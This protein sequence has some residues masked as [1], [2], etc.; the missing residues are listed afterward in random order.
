MF[1]RKLV[2]IVFN[3]YFFCFC[4]WTDF[5]NCW[6]LLLT[7]WLTPAQHK[8]I[9]AWNNRRERD[10]YAHTNTETAAAAARRRWKRSWIWWLGVRGPYVIEMRDFYSSISYKTVKILIFV[11]RITCFV[12]VMM[13]TKNNLCIWISLFTQI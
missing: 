9:Y 3:F 10:T 11:F 5:Q 8:H 12:Q 1:S 7:R 4:F 6:F 13:G 2:G